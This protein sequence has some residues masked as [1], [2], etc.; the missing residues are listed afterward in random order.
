MAKLEEQ[1]AAY[2]KDNC[3]HRRIRALSMAAAIPSGI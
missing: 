3:R 2:Q 1:I